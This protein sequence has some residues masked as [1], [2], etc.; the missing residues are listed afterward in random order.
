MNFIQNLF[1]SFLSILKVILWSRL[2][3]SNKRQKKQNKGKQLIIVGNGPSFR[4]SIEKYQ[5]KLI[6]S[7]ILSVNLFCCTDYFEKLKPSN[8]LLL[9]S[10]FFKTDKDLSELYI[11]NNIKVFSS[12]K[13]KTSWPMNLYIP[14]KYK[15]ARNI[16]DLKSQNTNITFH[17]FN[18]TPIEGLPFIGPPK[19]L[20]HPGI[21]FP[22]VS[23]I[24]K[25]PSEEPKTITVP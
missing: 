3:R 1:L 12:L 23:T 25:L 9:G 8:Y 5:N 11:S 17:Y 14:V 16:I 20:G 2:L 24:Y 21:S 7:N 18:T 19:S 10:E 15:K 13:T 4:L 6:E 22:F